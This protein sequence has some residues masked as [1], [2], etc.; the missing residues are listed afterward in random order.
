MHDDTQIEPATIEDLPAL[1]DLLFDLFSIESDFNP[2]RAKQL[3]GLRM[4]I[5][6]PSRGRI[7]VLRRHGEIL[8]MI[9]LLFTISTA[10]GGAVILLEDL[11]IRRDHRRQGHGSRLVQH[12]IRYAREKG[13][14]RITLLTERGDETVISFYRKHGFTLS[15]MVPMRLLLETGAAAAGAEP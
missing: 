12:A 7:F 1:A 10:E 9:N 13:F 8:G 15:N 5:E 14:L 4:I 3:R 6:T 11:V 2:D